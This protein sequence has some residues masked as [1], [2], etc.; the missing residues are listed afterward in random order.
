VFILFYFGGFWSV[1]FFFLLLPFS[2]T[3]AKEMSVG[4]FQFS[5]PTQVV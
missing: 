1:F 2:Y 3:G 4:T 5:I